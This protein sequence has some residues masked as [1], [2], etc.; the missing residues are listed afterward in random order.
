[1]FSGFGVRTL[2]ADQPVYNPL[3][4]HNGTVWPHDNALVADGLARYGLYPELATLFAGL[5]HAM[6]FFR[7]CRIPELFCGIERGSGPLVRYPVAGSP[8]AWSAASPFLLLQSI[9]GLRVDA[10]A[11]RLV[12]KNPQMPSFLRRIEFRNM[13]V[14]SAS[15]SMRFRRVGGRCHIDRLDVSGGPLKTE[16]EMD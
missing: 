14:G 5:Y 7:D 11:R 10:P 13:R 8:Q 15:V 1:M 6:A 2:A 16:I 9:L 12:V 3:S 4:Y